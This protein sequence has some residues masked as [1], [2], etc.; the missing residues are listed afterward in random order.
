MQHARLHNPFVNKRP[1]TSART[2]VHF[3]RMRASVTCR[4]GDRA[5]R[6]Q[7]EYEYCN[8]NFSGPRSS[9][10]ERAALR[11]CNDGGERMRM[12]IH[13][14]LPRRLRSGMRSIAR[15]IE[16][17]PARGRE[18]PGAN[19]GESERMKKRASERDGGNE[20]EIRKER[21]RDTYEERR[22]REK[23]VPSE[24]SR[25]KGK[26]PEEKRRRERERDEKA[27][28]GTTTRWR[29]RKRREVEKPEEEPPRGR[30]VRERRRARAHGSRKRQQ[31]LRALP[32]ESPSA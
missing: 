28:A 7:C 20:K 9:A 8:Y 10:I 29:E 5:S 2:L 15:R 31:L 21:E 23:E 18:R 1:C 12:H 25:G 16:S 11:D 22:D 14:S 13:I 6:K 26:G 32:L 19:E 4:R 27:Q 24:R 17:G 3:E 30:R